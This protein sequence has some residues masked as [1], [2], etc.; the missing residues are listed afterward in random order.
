MMGLAGC[1]A[2]SG[3]PQAFGD[4]GAGNVSALAVDS[5]ASVPNAPAIVGRD[6]AGVY[7]MTSICTHQ[8]CDMNVDGTITSSGV[9]C[10]CHGSRFDLQ[11][12]PVSGP[13]NTPLEH[14]AVTVDATGEITI[15]GGTT[16]TEITRTAVTAS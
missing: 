14:Y 7:A 12:N 13:A 16:A 3:A 15:H 11:G 1:S 9:L 5:I 8:G 6:A 10:Q 4:V 2:P